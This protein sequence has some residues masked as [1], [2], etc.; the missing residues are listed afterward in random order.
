M[1]ISEENFA[2]DLYA[3]KCL[4]SFT[5]AL[6]AIY[7]QGLAADPTLAAQ[8]REGMVEAHQLLCG[9]AKQTA[10]S[11]HWTAVWRRPNQGGSSLCLQSHNQQLNYTADRQNNFY[12]GFA[13][14]T[15]G[16]AYF[17]QLLPAG[18]GWSLQSVTAEE[19][20][21]V[22]LNVA[23]PWTLSPN[24]GLP[25]PEATFVSDWAMAARVEPKKPAAKLC[26][27]CKIPL[28]EG[29]SFCQ[30][31]GAPVHDLVCA[32]CQ[33]S[34]VAGAKFCGWCGARCSA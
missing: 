13:W 10:G 11:G 19:L 14:E 23:L 6:R 1:L 2:L 7:V 34:L 16:A 25:E 20:P 32:S 27:A 31:C 9:G 22:T 15:G 17:F 29:A 3:S 24:R 12:G 8:L 26:T 30:R 21:A 4:D 33:K 18:A 28:L 5:A